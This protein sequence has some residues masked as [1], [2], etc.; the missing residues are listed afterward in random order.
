M[1][2]TDFYTDA[3]I[4]IL[5]TYS[6]VRHALDEVFQ[7][8][9]SGRASVFPRLRS[10][11]GDIKLSAMGG[12]WRSRNVAGIK[13][14]PTVNGNYSFLIS[15]FDT[16]EN[17]PLAVLQANEVTRLRTAALVALVASSVAEPRARKLALIGAGVQGCAIA[18]ALSER[19]DFEQICVADPALNRF[20]ASQLAARLKAHV[21]L[22]TS[23]EAVREADIVITASR[24]RTPVFDGAWLK[25]GCF[26]AAVGTSLPDGREL[27]DDTLRRAGRV[28]VEWKPQ[29]MV[30]AGEIVL[31]KAA[32][33]LSDDKI[34]DLGE[35]Y[36]GEKAWRANTD[37]IVVFKSVGVGLADV[38]TAWLAVQKASASVSASVGSSA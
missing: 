15:L 12:I 22:C 37:E 9:A 30:E 18:E 2:S 17:K 14:Y 13:T 1:K 6:D 35:T 16:L 3:E 23:E 4:A 31:G 20:S 27:D 24:S 11:C 38:A 8:L 36:R 21:Q 34:I 7:D 5:L 26:V 10:N 28:I 32:G 33:A 29:S 19:F 25:P